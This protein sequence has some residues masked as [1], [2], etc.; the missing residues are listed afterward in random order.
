VAPV[1]LVSIAEAFLRMDTRER[2]KCHAPFLANYSIMNKSTRACKCDVA[3]GQYRKVMKYIFG[4]DEHGHYNKVV[5]LQKWKL[6]KDTSNYSQCL[7]CSQEG[8]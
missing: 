8:Q 5:Q 4:T 1:L 2:N 6:S 7:S 3:L